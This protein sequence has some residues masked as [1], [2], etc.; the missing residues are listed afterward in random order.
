MHSASGS[1]G[2][3]RR[4]VDRSL[5]ARFIR[6]A[7]SHGPHVSSL[8]S[9]LLNHPLRSCSSQ[10]REPPKSPWRSHFVMKGTPIEKH[11]SRFNILINRPVPPFLPCVMQSSLCRSACGPAAPQGAIIRRLATNVPP[12]STACWPATRSSAPRSACAAAALCQGASGAAV[13]QPAQQQQLLLLSSKKL[14]HQVRVHS[15]QRQR[16]TRCNASAAGAAGGGSDRAAAPLAE[17]L[18][19][20]AAAAAA[21]AQAQFLPLAL[22][23]AIAAGCAYPAAGVAVGQ[24]PNLTAFVTTAMFVISGLQLRQGEAAQALKARGARGAWRGRGALHPQRAAGC[25]PPPPLRP[26]AA[27]APAYIPSP[28]RLARPPRAAA[29]VYGVAAILFITPLVSLAVLALPLQPPVL[30]LGL[31]VFCCMPTA[32]S[33]GITLTQVSAP[34]AP[35]EHEAPA[36]RARLAD[37]EAGCACPGPPPWQQPRAAQRPRPR[38]GRPSHPPTRPPARRAPAP[39]PRAASRRQ[40]R[41]RAAPHCGL[42][43]AGRLHYALHAAGA[44]G[45]Q[46]R[47]RRARAAAA[48]GES[49]PEHPAAHSVWRGGARLCSRCGRAGGRADG[50]RGAAHCSAWAL[51][52]SDS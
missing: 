32:L 23:T 22:V 16:R 48:A 21:F 2:S 26:P 15:H 49:C 28:P 35:A 8:L 38:L 31:A 40:R 18:T 42:Q 37:P 4:V 11:E 9:R 45:A 5:T 12:L 51:A 52:A 34:S 25:T 6:P 7:G 10:Q 33:S 24:L 17:R 30:A 29:V 20:V 13:C 14:Q 47:R 44:A 27:R 3:P 39:R 41:A 19:A 43:H 46:P 1:H 50:G 36:A